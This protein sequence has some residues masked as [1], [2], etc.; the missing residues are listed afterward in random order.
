[1]CTKSQLQVVSEKV[2]RLAKEQFGDKL[3]KVILYG[4]YARGDYDDESDIDIMVLVD[5]PKEELASFKKPFIYLSSDMG[6]EYDLVITITLKDT[7]T[8][9][10]YLEAVPFYH[11]VQ[12]EGVLIAG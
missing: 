1:M 12:K 11:T 3:D 2:A 6:L 7:E 4:S 8:Y 10:R 5:L 9:Y